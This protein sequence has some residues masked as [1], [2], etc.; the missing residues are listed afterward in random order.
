MQ[1]NN[2]K[3]PGRMKITAGKR[4]ICPTQAPGVAFGLKFIYAPVVLFTVV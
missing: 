3:T 2:K 1:A 4:R